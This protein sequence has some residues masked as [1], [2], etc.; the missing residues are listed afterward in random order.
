MKTAT[1]ISTILI[2]GFILTIAPLAH[3]A[4]VDSALGK[5]NTIG[6]ITGFGETRGGDVGLYEKIAA[7]IN[8]LLGFAGVVA[9]IFIIYAGFRW[10]TASGNEE[11]VKEARGNIRNAVI[12][13]VV[14]FLAFVITNFVTKSLIDVIGG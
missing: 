13:L 6:G 10:I 8:I 14:I 4:A 5:L 1:I 9:V 7:V 12:G 3:A 11:Q 2:S